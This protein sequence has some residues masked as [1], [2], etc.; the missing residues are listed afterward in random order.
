VYPT[1]LFICDYLLEHGEGYAQEIWRELKKVRE[2]RNVCTY[3]S[4][5]RNY[6]YVLKKLGLIEEVRTEE[7]PG[8]PEWHR[9]RY[10]RIV[11]G[12]ENLMDEW[13]NPQKVWKLK[14]YG[15]YKHKSASS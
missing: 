1:A 2:G 9:R 14:R 8:H 7:V 12:K 6:V 3:D 5:K 13:T 11:Q 15:Y 10:Y 4:F